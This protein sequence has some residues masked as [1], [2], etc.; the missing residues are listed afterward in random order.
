LGALVAR[1][2]DVPE[3]VRARITAC[4]R[5]NVTLGGGGVVVVEAGGVRR[6]L[7]LRRDAYSDARYT[8]A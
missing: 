8:S 2:L 3:D 6:W 7:S 4:T 5:R 1:G